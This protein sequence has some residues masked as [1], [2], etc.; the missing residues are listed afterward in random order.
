[1]GETAETQIQRLVTLVAWM[2][3]RDAGGPIRYRDAARGVGLTEASLRAD[4]Q[5]LLDLTE[6]YKP[7]LGSLSVSITAGGFTLGSR[8]AFQRPLRLSRDEALALILG[9][10]GVRGG[11]ELAGRIGAPFATEAETAEAGRTW[12][13]GPTPG[14]GTAQA[15]AILRRARD[16][17]RK[18]DLL[19]CGSD[20][21]PSRRVIHPHQLVQAGRAWYVVAWCEKA[22]APRHFRVD[23][24]LELTECDGQFEIRPDLKR[25]RAPG[26]L[27]ST[28]QTPVATIAFSARIARWI[29]EQY[30]EGEDSPDGRYIVRVPVAD[31]RWLARE[32]LQYGAEAEVVAPDGL[33][34]FMRRWILT[35]DP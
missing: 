34:E 33:R 16:E 35:P 8:G 4:L 28:D 22:R 15:L 6:S 32:V 14:P 1:M 10:G 7:W 31:P 24:M 26:D 18:V 13:M 21:E 9:L 17:R 27:L 11:K 30:P 23:R 12:A 5:V 29:R 20:G 25:V 2:S 3:Q 19:Y